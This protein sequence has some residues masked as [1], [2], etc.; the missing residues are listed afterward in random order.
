M[1][2]AV[3]PR[4][5]SKVNR[6]IDKGWLVKSKCNEEGV[7]PLMAVVQ[8]K[9]DQMRPPLDFREL[10]EL[11]NAAGQTQMLVTTN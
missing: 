6:W 4:F 1:D 9:K 11:L 7:I 10:N 8:E 3:Y 5:K 2:E